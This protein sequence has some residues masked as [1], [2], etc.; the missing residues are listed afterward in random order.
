MRLNLHLGKD[1]D[2]VLLGRYALCVGLGPCLVHADYRLRPDRG[3]R[4]IR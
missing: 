4:A 2:E 1:T 3:L